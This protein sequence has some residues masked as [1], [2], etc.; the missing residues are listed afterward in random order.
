MTSLCVEFA[1]L[2]LEGDVA[3]GCDVCLASGARCVGMRDALRTQR[4]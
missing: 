3:T 2:K 1:T 4:G